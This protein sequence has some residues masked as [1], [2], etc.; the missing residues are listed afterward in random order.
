MDVDEE[1]TP[2]EKMKRSK[3]ETRNRRVEL[4]EDLFLPD[5]PSKEFEFSGDKKRRRMMNSNIGRKMGVRG[6]SIFTDIHNVTPGPSSAENFQN[7]LENIFNIQESPIPDKG[8]EFVALS[9]T[10]TLHFSTNRPLIRMIVIPQHNAGAPD[11]LNLATTPT[12]LHGFLSSTKSHADGTPKKFTF[13]NE[14]VSKGVKGDQNPEFLQIRNDT[15]E[16]VNVER[17]FLYSPGAINRSGGMTK[18]MSPIRGGLISPLRPK[19]GGVGVNDMNFVALASPVPLNKSR[20][21]DLQMVDTDVL[22]VLGLPTP[23]AE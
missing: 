15:D 4:M 11:L 1:L 22:G 14:D 10:G 17:N 5:S 6:L 12:L 2:A 3:E 19:A 21:S 8:D 13:S 16:F 20:P 7:N 23:K 9:S 18:L